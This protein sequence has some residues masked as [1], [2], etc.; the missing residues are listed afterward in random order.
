[1]PI[2]FR[3]HTYWVCHLFV[4][5]LWNDEWVCNMYPCVTNKHIF[6]FKINYLQNSCFL[7]YYRQLLKLQTV[8]WKIKM[9]FWHSASED[10]SIFCNVTQLLDF[11]CN[12]TQLCTW[13]FAKLPFSTV[14]LWSRK[15]KATFNASALDKA[16]CVAKW[17]KALLWWTH[18]G[19]PH[20]GAIHKVRQ[21][22]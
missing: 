18:Q 8:N 4:Y 5:F 11:F 12:F 14:D 17:Q 16:A 6:S 20:Y 13:L 1:M 10:A 22:F 9:Q 3:L 7:H 19:P 15:V 21:D 2:Q